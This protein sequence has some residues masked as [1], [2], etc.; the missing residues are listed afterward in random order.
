MFQA[1]VV[2][3]GIV[4]AILMTFGKMI[5]SIWLIDFPLAPVST[6]ISMIKKPFAY[7][8]F[9]SAV[10]KVATRKQKKEQISGKP[11]QSLNQSTEG[12]NS[13]EA[14]SYD[15]PNQFESQ[16]APQTASI[17]PNPTSS[18]IPKPRSLYPPSI[19]GLA[20]VARGEVGYLIASLAE[21]QGIFS[22][23]PSGGISE[24]YLV[25]IWAISICTLIGPISVGTLVRRVKKL[26]QARNDTGAFPLGVWGI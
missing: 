4:Y 16:V 15:N 5:T 11:D 26:E 20:M 24:I 2:W 21:S 14:S 23:E 18:L 19:L 8:S 25:V 22:K 6:L 17:N 9:F 12:S 1:S 3:R 10:P 13:T 7:V